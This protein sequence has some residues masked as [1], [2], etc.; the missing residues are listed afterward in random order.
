MSER[1][2]GGEKIEVSRE[3][4]IKRNE[5]WIA[6]GRIYRTLEKLDR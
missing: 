6:L 1:D 3:R 4:E 2:L 5:V